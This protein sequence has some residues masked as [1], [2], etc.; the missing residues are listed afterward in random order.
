MAIQENL[1][2]NNKE[3][4]LLESLTTPKKCKKGS[5]GDQVLLHLYCIFKSQD[6]CWNTGLL[7]SKSCIGLVE[8]LKNEII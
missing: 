6:S 3:K 8:N 7:C 4:K 1:S 5:E 2:V